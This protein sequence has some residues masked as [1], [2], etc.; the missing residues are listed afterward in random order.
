MFLYISLGLLFTYRPR[1]GIRRLQPLSVLTLKGKKTWENPHYLPLLHT[2]TRSLC[3]A[4]CPFN[5]S[6]SGP[7]RCDTLLRMTEHT[8]AFVQGLT[9]YMSA[10]R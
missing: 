6:R 10:P 1:P 5:V 7:A 2:H 9:V 8:L 3:N 4:R